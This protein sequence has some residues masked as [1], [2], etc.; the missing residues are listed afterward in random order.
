MKKIFVLII[1]AILI[2]SAVACSEVLG[3]EG[4]SDLGSPIINQSEDRI[5]VRY[6]VSSFSELCSFM[7]VDI[8]PLPSSCS[9]LKYEKETTETDKKCYITFSGNQTNNP[10]GVLEISV[11]KS[12]E[13]DSES[14]VEYSSADGS[15]YIAKWTVISPVRNSN[16]TISVYYMMK[17][18]K[19]FI[20]EDN[21]K[22]LVEEYI[23]LQQEQ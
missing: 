7:K 14:D 12:G 10:N 19:S 6:T 2:L 1:S 4:E 9:I 21:F 15:W 8:T 5:G 16:K 13:A 11:S 23:S 22:A 3:G 17:E 20:P 18:D